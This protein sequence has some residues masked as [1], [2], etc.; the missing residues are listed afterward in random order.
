MIVVLHFFLE[1][2]A[3]FRFPEI[4]SEYAMTGLLLYVPVA[5]NFALA[6]LSMVVVETPAWGLMVLVVT[7]SDLPLM[8]SAVMVNE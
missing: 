7:A 2:V 3:S 5:R 4:E 8:F 1:Y 6:L